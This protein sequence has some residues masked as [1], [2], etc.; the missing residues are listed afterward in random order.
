M[1]KRVVQRF[2]HV[3]LALALCVPAAFWSI[4]VIEFERNDVEY[5]F[6]ALW[7]FGGLVPP[8]IGHEEY[9]LWRLFLSGFLHLTVSHL[10]SN[11]L[12]F[13]SA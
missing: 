10:L 7:K 1:I 11:V 9:Q 5:S 4:Y 6:L 3:P 12:I 2:L 13:F 8:S